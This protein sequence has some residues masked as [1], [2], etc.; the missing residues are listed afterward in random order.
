MGLPVRSLD[1]SALYCILTSLMVNFIVRDV[2]KGWCSK[3]VRVDE[4]V[5]CIL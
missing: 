1:G 5:L 3:I 2:G 4:A